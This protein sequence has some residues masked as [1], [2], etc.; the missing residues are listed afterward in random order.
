MIIYI[1]KKLREMKKIILLSAI[2][3]TTALYA[4]DNVGIGT[5]NPN[6]KSILDLSSTD[7]GFLAPRMST[8]QRLAIAPSATEEALLVFDTDLKFY[9]YWNGTQWVQLPGDNAFNT[10]LNFDPNTNTLSITDNGGTLST[11]LNLNIND[12]DSNPANELITNVVFGQGNILTIEEGG[13]SWSTT[14]NVN[15]A[16]SNPQ[17]ELNTSFSLNGTT[18]NISDAG[19]TLS[20]DLSGIVPPSS[21]DWKITGNAGTNVIN[22]YIGT[23]DATGLS[24]RTNATERIRITAN[25]GFVGI[26]TTTPGFILDVADRIR[27]RSGVGGSSAGLWLTDLANANNRAFIGMLDDNT[28]GFY[29]GGLGNWYLRTNVNNGN[30]DIW[31]KLTVSRDNIAECCNN[32]ATLALAENTSVTNRVS[33]IS[34]HNGSQAEGQLS[35]VS[36]NTGLTIPAIRLRLGT[37]GL[38]GGNMGLQI[39]GGLFY[40]NADSRTETRDNAGLQ[41]NAGAQSGFYETNNP[42]NF[43]AG[44][45]NWWHLIDT[46][47]SNSGNNYAMQIAGSFFDQRIYYR[48]TNNNPSQPWSEFVTTNNVNSFV[49]NN[50]N[51]FITITRFNFNNADNITFNTGIS[52]T[53]F[54]AII[55]GVN[56]NGDGDIIDGLRSYMFKQNGTWWIRYDNRNQT[57]NLQ[58]IDVMFINSNVVAGDNR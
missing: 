14:I 28:L 43:P 50:N 3:Y 20:V 42:V 11:T 38:S 19:G 25:T 35:L 17:N 54:S 32:D 24:I 26:G 40:G 41:G 58:F 9:F 2:L 18:L 31:G 46:R 8:A 23:S 6:S 39:T 4:Q 51:P 55:A 22:N 29:G 10:S 34:F 53:Q 7:K 49:I 56:T 48:K 16:D 57:D 36:N 13:N 52:A 1:C 37:Q 30:T 45:T 33:S 15:D 5:L 44:A 27:L 47:H 21:D 12:A